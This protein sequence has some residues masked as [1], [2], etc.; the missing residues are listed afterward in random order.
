MY[1]A[2]ECGFAAS[3]VVT[4]GSKRVYGSV[5]C[6][7]F[8]IIKAKGVPAVKKKWIAPVVAVV[9]VLA[10]AVLVVPQIWPG[11]AGGA[12]DAGQTT[13][14]HTHEA[15]VLEKMEGVDALLVYQTTPGKYGLYSFGT[16][17]ATIVDEQG[18]VLPL[19]AIAPGTFILFTSQ[20]EYVL[21]SEPGQYLNMSEVVVLE[22]EDDEMYRK[23]VKYWTEEFL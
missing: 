13:A 17:N 20:D 14:S 9:A 18:A 23:A 15:V 4:K 10:A 8:G 2:P 3:G 6:K 1:A 19:S 11:K 22:K 12:E 7:C 16:E 21:A 5:R